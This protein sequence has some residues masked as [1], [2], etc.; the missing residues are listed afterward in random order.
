[1]TAR[2]PGS[3]TLLQVAPGVRLRFDE[4]RELYV[5]RAG[6]RPVV[7]G[8]HTLAIVDAFT[9]P[10]TMGEVARLLGEG[11]QGAQ[12]WIDL[13]GEIV[14][15]YRGGILVQVSDGLS[16]AV[17]EY[18]GPSASE[19]RFQADMLN[20]E[21]R[22]SAFV[23]AVRDAVRPGDVVVEVGTGSGVL[24]VT[25][26][27]AGARRVYA[28]EAGA[29]ADVAEAVFQDNEVGH[30]VRLVRGWSA[31]ARLPERADVLVFELIGDGPLDEAVIEVL[32]DARQRF[33]KPG[34]RIVPG[35]LRIFGLPVSI[36]PEH[37]AWPALSEDAVDRW[38]QRYQ[39]DLTSL[40]GFAR[41][42]EPVFYA[43]WQ[44][45]SEWLGVG[46]PGLLAD[47]DF[48]SVSQARLSK[49]VQCD[50]RQPAFLNGVL[51]YFEL[52]VTPTVTLSTS[53]REGG[54]HHHWLHEVYVLSSTR[55]VR[56]GDL[57][58]MTYRYR[59]EHGPNGLEC[60]I[61]SRGSE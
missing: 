42:S 53:P 22:T 47:L 43:R 8:A 57:V 34:G 16:D 41:R 26:A 46:E 55:R 2:L 24:A 23:T 37:L 50:V 19:L 56:P 60:S 27:K 33:L 35:R 30:R 48:Y 40:L 21:A 36:P 58:T 11:M 52:D 17:S 59:D 32:L 38:R 61:E 18:A 44:K 25:A 45:A 39:V 15:L 9:R 49:T 7:G 54:T 12:G 20:D 28:I 3:S 29:I 14:M 13:T 4:D 31:E 1:M 5:E 6:L 10:R 51:L